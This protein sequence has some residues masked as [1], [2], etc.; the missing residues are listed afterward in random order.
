[1][2]DLTRFRLQDMTACSTALRRLGDDAA[3]LE[4]AADR[5]TRFLYTNLTTG[6]AEAPACVLV[7][8]FKT[9]P[10]RLL[11]P[12]LQAVADRG[13]EGIPSQSDM[14][15]LML[16]AST[17]AVPGWNDPA[18][19]S[20]F[21]VIPLAGPNAL[22]KLPMFSQLFAQFHIDLPYLEKSPSP[23]FIDP[24]A[25]TSN[26]F[27]IPR[28]LDS[29]YVPGQQEFVV[30]FG[31]QS[32][33]GF[34]GLLATGEL[35]AVIAFTKV[36]V[37][38]DT[39]DLFAPLALS[40]KLALTRFEEA[41]LLPSTQPAK[42]PRSTPQESPDALRDRVNTLEALLAVQEHVVEDQ[43]SRLDSLLAAS[44]HQT[45]EIKKQ[46][47]RFEA[48]AATSPIGIFQTDEAGRCLYTN[49]A[50]QTIMG[51]S[52]SDPLGDGWK[53]A[54]FSEDQ[55]RVFSAWN[56]TTRQGTEC[57]LEFRMQ[58]P[59][60][61]VRW[62]QARSRPLR[63]GSGQVTGHVGTTEDIT[64]R[65]QAEDAAT[66]S[67]NTLKSFVE[68]TPAAVAM[69]DRNLRYLAVS[70]R[71]RQDY[72]LGE[73]D[74][75][76]KHH[77]EL[78]PEI[79]AMPEW[80]AI[81]QR[82]LAGAVERREEDRFV[83]TDGSEDWLRWEVRPWQ[84]STGAIGGI[85]M[86]TEVITERRRAEESLRQSEA[87]LQEAQAM[88]HLG[89]WELDLVDNRLL[90]SD[91]I[92][93]IF[94]I[95]KSTFSASYEAF[96]NTVHP[97]DRA[98][99]NEAYTTSVQNRTPYEIVHRLQM[100]DGRIKYVQERCETVYDADGRPRRSIGTVQDITERL[101][102]KLQLERSQ[103]LLTSIFEHLPHMVFVKD[104]QTLRFVEFNKAGEN[105][106][107][108]SRDELLGKSDYDFFPPEEADFFTEKDRAVLAAGT[109]LEIPEEEIKTKY[110]GIRLLR[111]KKVPLYDGQQVP[112]YLLGISEDITERKKSEAT[113]FRLQQAIN[114]AQDGIALLDSAGSF[115]YM[116]P[117]YAMIYG[118]LPDELL[119]R[120]WQTLYP[121]E[122]AAT[123]ERVYLPALREQGHWRGEVVGKQKSG[124]VFYLDLSL[125]LL[126]R[127]DARGEHILF[128]CRDISERRKMELELLKAKES[129]E[130]GMRA[131]SEFLATMSHEIRTPMNGVLG[132]TGL[133]LD[134]TLSPEQQD[135]ARTLKQSGESLMR[136]INDVL[137]FSKIEAGKLTI[138]RIP[139]DLRMTVEDTLELL[140]PAAQEKQLEL[141]GLID[142]RVP[143]AVIGDPGRIRQILSNLVGNAI[144]FTDRGE[145]TVH[146][147]SITV[148][149]TTI[150]LRFEI[151]DTGMGL[152]KEA[153]AKLFQAFT[154]ADGSTSR[155]YGGTGLGLTICKRLTDLMGGQIGLR[156]SPGTGT[157]V[158]FTIPLEP[159][160]ATIQTSPGPNLIESLAGLHVCLIDD[161]ATNRRLLQH[162]V[163]AWKMS[164]E[165]VESA[166]SALA[167]MR[168]AVE[169]GRPFDLA[170]VDRQL[171][172][173]DGLELGRAV[174]ADPALR[175]T[176]LVLLA[177][178]GYRG[179]A[180][181]ALEAGFSG[182]LTKPVRKAQ[183][184]DCLRLVMGRTSMVHSQPPAEGTPPP[185]VTR[186]QVANVQ[187]SGRLLIV[188]DN[189]V[190][191]KVAAKL[192]E[193]LG[194]RTDVAVNGKEALLALARHPYRLIFMDC[195]MPE[196]DGFETTRLI[197]RHESPDRRVPVIAM[198]ANAMSGDRE[199]CLAS[200]MDDFVSKPVKSADL[201]QMLTRWLKDPGRQAAA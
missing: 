38:Q 191:Q 157:C 57:A 193:K 184:Y 161:N 89:N 94:E 198:T 74:I 179:D 71:W 15:C 110:R 172:G 182:Y 135:Y 44:L 52:S 55:D 187:A 104:A 199:Q 98:R 30:P 90:W 23:I 75:L 134:T 142:A 12:E 200:G 100:P 56:A 68:H 177:S 61:T 29:P 65:K 34:G 37:Q 73:R 95:D 132:M 146:I 138:E 42:H 47:F 155:K 188:D 145:V 192:L 88:A 153:Q 196:L 147:G 113:R 190:N 173:M 160:P 189:P 76:G 105:L 169:R 28:A 185:L 159:Q 96:L 59:D 8:L 174:T 154:Q 1:M 103:A 195:Q 137:D 85:I 22:A 21:R 46:S 82:C 3:S 166:Q 32:V 109:M 25:T 4:E 140:A 48:L 136:I 119:G 91:E 62:V 27:Y 64:E 197:R 162:H 87:R 45:E 126:E 20:R 163:S 168:Q 183:L 149:P 131:K 186:H 102:N 54:V 49:T 139:F 10:Y 79:A 120:G 78:F 53:Q 108:F 50:L 156:S 178:V 2:F 17:G 106:T 36:P 80:Q 128:V 152:T 41:T 121:D 7:R 130:A 39:A 81:H 40:T 5:I 127:T 9:H 112:R 175:R 143:T 13:L 201:Q 111:T 123:I 176:P 60:G 107:G 67:R 31:V 170:I 122:W 171:P 115:A 114:H 6:S 35:F 164:H 99:V 72:R 14:K 129:A 133:L 92:F 77:Y 97:E 51:L 43:T 125:T 16:L 33:L 158:W 69:L 63:D 86:F 18:Q 150:M 194:Y 141:V 19:S 181:E 144:K 84:D 70:T 101:E 148:S 118:Y 116:N 93:R 165:S 11:S 24:H 66:R 26:V 167:L 151:I 124:A 180:K 83:R 58:Q 117:A